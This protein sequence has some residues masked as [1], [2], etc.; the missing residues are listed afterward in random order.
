MLRTIVLLAVSLLCLY[1]LFH[2]IFD[3]PAPASEQALADSSS[4]TLQSLQKRVEALESDLDAAL[5]ARQ[6]LE[7]RLNLLEHQELERRSTEQE[8]VVH[9]SSAEA[10]TEP[11]LNP[12]Q[13]RLS[14]QTELLQQGLDVTVI[15]RI[16]QHVD[17]N[18]LARLEWRDRIRR[19][20]A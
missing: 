11:A 1:L 19:K 4:I 17:A 10:R 2:S 20:N 13:R 9:D 15:E 12:E 8:G 3:R 7:K 6:Q 16:Q 14:Q 18:R 5:V